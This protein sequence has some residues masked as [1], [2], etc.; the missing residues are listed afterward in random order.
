MSETQTIWLFCSLVCLFSDKLSFRSL[1]MLSMPYSSM[2]YI[3]YSIFV[4]F[5]FDFVFVHVLFFYKRLTIWIL[6]HGKGDD[7]IRCV[8]GLIL[9]E[10]NFL[11]HFHLSDLPEFYL[12]T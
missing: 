4:M 6:T 3:S 9:S 12:F 11:R 10:L 1:W 2:G 7:S 8:K 5:V